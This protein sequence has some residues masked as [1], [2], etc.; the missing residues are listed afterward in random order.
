MFLLPLA[1]R[2]FRTLP[3]A[4]RRT[5]GTHSAVSAIR[6]RRLRRFSEDSIFSNR[7]EVPHILSNPSPISER[8]IRSVR[9]SL[10]VHAH[11]LLLERTSRVVTPLSVGF[12]LSLAST[13]SH[14]SSVFV[15]RNQRYL[16]CLGFSWQYLMPLNDKDK[17]NIEK[18]KRE[19]FQRNGVFKILHSINVL[20]HPRPSWDKDHKILQ[21]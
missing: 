7:Q 1:R 13:H 15:Q 6:A 20:S 5:R 10:L 18:S 11:C 21:A 14:G 17:M 16:R 3:A 9:K 2:I 19:K 8:E 4:Y 12:Y